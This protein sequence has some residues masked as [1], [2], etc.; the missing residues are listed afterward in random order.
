MTL[1]QISFY[2]PETHLEEV[3]MSM[4][5]AGAGKL[6]KYECCSWQTEGTG[7][8]KPMTGSTPFLG[9]TGEIEIV[10]EYKV[11]M[12]CEAKHV[13]GVVTA[14]KEYHPYETPAYNI[15]KL[16]RF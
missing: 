13:K 6:G 14:L 15:M 10:K 9:K 16:I 11:E 5:K 1:Y 7:Q 2:V 4:F 8:F 3:K 12:L